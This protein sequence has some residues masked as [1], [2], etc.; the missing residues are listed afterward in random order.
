MIV[1]VDGH[2]TSTMER[3]LASRQGKDNPMMMGNKK[4]MEIN[5]ASGLI[6]KVAD[7]RVKDQDFAKELAEQIYDNAMIQAGL[8]IDPQQMVSRNY[9][10]LERIAA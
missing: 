10:I 6:K 3:I 8:L 7:L 9:P 2:M 4:D 5:P 1:N